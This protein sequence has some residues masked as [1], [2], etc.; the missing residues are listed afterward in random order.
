MLN[1]KNECFYISNSDVIHKTHFP[2]NINF[3]RKREPQHGA[4]IGIRGGLT[5]VHLLESEDHE[6]DCWQRER[7]QVAIIHCNNPQHIA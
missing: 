2:Q 4:A 5:P 7:T 6:T 3:I 1:K